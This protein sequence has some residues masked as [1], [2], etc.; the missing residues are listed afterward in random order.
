VTVIFS[1]V[2]V[3]ILKRFEFVIGFIEYLKLVTTSKDYALTVLNTWRTTVGYTRFFQTVVPSPMSYV[4]VLTVCKLDLNFRTEDS[5]Q[6]RSLKLL[7]FKLKLYCDRWPVGQFV[8][9][10][11]PLWIRWPDLTFLWETITF[12]HL[13][14]GRP[15]WWEDGAVICSAIKQAQI[16]VVLRPTVSR[17]VHLGV[18]PP[19]GPMTRF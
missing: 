1:R 11:G 18:G 16:Q 10:S 8:L 14:V 6:I 12:F 17:P 9:V 5:T 7:K 19:V 13:H 3:W 2:W 4:Y 15:L